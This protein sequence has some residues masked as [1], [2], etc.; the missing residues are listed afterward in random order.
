MKLEVKF[1]SN[2][3][4]TAEKTFAPAHPED[5]GVDLYAAE[6]IQIPGH[7]R[8]QVKT[9][10]AI[11]IPKGYWAKI[12][13]KSGVALNTPLSLKAGVVDAD[14]TGELLLVVKNDQFDRWTVNQGDKLAQIVFHK[15]VAVGVKVVTEFSE[16]TL[17]GENG[18]GSTDNKTNPTSTL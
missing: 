11:K 4:K 9:G 10:V 1:L 16:T 2:Y 8:R 17:R 3:P 6:T 15:R 12:E 7:S 13:E 5:V 14:Y 18:F